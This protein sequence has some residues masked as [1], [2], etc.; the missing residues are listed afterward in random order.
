MPEGS[1][2][3]YR[4]IETIR[5]IWIFC[6]SKDNLTRWINQF[7]HSL[8]DNLYFKLPWKR[9]LMK[10][11]WE[12]GENAGN[13]HFLLFSQCLIPFPKR[14]S[15]FLSHLCC[16]LQMH[17]ITTRI[18]FCRLVTWAQ[19]PMRQVRHSPHRYF[20][21]VRHAA[22]QEKGWCSMMPHK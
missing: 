8:P 14:N 15:F 22:P 1:V 19:T 21:F 17:S 13:Q 9:S 16:L 5:C 7:F 2:P 11:L 3:S 6:I 10:T 12:K 20:R 18:K 4:R